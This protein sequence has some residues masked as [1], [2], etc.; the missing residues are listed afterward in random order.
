MLRKVENGEISWYADWDRYEKHIYD[1][2]TL[3]S[4]SNKIEKQKTNATYKSKTEFAWFCKA[5]QKPD[6]CSKE[7]PHPGWVGN[8]FA[9]LTISVHHVG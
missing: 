7:S 8:Q 3:V 5:Y 2:I 4:Q 9:S 6:G 1:K